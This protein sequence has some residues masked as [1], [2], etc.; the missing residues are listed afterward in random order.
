VEASDRLIKNGATPKSQ[1]SSNLKS[2]N[3]KKLLL[4]LLVFIIISMNA[5]SQYLRNKYSLICGFPKNDKFNSSLVSGFEFSIP[6]LNFSHFNGHF[7]WEINIFFLH[8]K[9][10][11]V[12][13]DYFYKDY[14]GG[15]LEL[16]FFPIT[17]KTVMPFIGGIFG[18]MFNFTN[19]NGKYG[20]GSIM[21]LIGVKIF[22]QQNISVFSSFRYG[23]IKEEFVNNVQFPRTKLFLISTGINFAI[24]LRPTK[25]EIKID[26]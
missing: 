3:M 16:N 4:L 12:T 23:S 7:T 22:L 9:A 1:I 19:K 10:K 18:S 26:L 15:N 5:H 8:T 14:W 13:R 21:P 17:K 11:Y 6:A 24:P 25:K 2:N 20:T